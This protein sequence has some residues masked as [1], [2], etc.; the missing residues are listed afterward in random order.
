MTA[1]HSG[2]SLAVVNSLPGRGWPYS[3]RMWR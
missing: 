3:Q 1:Q 2:E